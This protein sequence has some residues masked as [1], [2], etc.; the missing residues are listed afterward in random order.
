MGFLGSI[1]SA[2]SSA[3]HS[4][5]SCV[6][7]ICSSIAGALGGTA[8]G[9]AITSFVTKIGVVMPGLDIISAIFMIVDTVCKIAE[10][11][12]IKEKEKDEPDELAMKAEK[13]NKK[14]ED[15]DTVESY[16]KHLQQDIQLTKEEREKLENMSPEEK[17]AY[18]AT[19]TYLYAKACSE[20][21]GFDT[22]GLKNPEL[23]GLTVDIL[24]DLSKI[25]NILSPSEFV[26]YSR[27][28]Q[29]NGMGMKEFSDYLHNRSV[30]LSTDEKVQSALVDAM[31]ELSPSISDDDINQKLYGMNIKD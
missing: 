5:C 21:L 19:G 3:F 16:I 25:Q 30:D 13:D 1:G 27:F 11:L 12:G 31:K 29:A 2:L 4:V 10:V 28:L 24:A 20:K 8:L 26:V 17:A 6:S 22:T 15:F 18:R 14:P 9:S 7:S 23:V